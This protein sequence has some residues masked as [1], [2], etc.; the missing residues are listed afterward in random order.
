[1]KKFTLKRTILTL[2]LS[3]GLIVMPVSNN[4]ADAKTVSLDESL[5]AMWQHTQVQTGRVNGAYTGSL[6]SFSMRTPIRNWNIVSYTPPNFRAGCG[7]V[8][9]HFGSFSF[10]SGDNIKELMRQIMGSAL[11]YAV[12][13]AL[14]NVCA[15]CDE[16]LGDLQDLTAKINANSINTCKMSSTA[17]DWISGNKNSSDRKSEQEQ[18]SIDAASKGEKKDMSE[19]W[20]NIFSSSDGN[21]RKGNANR[22]A[23]AHNIDT[24]YGNNLLNT[25]VSTNLFE[26]IDTD[27]YGGDK[28]FFEIAMSLIGTNIM[29]TGSNKNNNSSQDRYIEPIWTLENLITGTP[30]NSQLDILSC[31]D[32]SQNITYSDAGKCQKVTTKQNDFKGT[33][34]V[35]IELLAGKQ[36]ALGDAQGDLL[37]SDIEPNSI[38]AWFKDNRGMTL[39]AE[40]Q[41]FVKQIPPTMYTTLEMV[42]KS[43]QD[44]ITKAVTVRASEILAE[45]MAANLATAIVSQTKMAYNA[46]ARK[47]AGS[48]EGKYIADMSANQKEAL[49][50]LERAANEVHRNADAKTDLFNQMVGRLILNSQQLEQMNKQ[51]ATLSI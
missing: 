20:S 17:I 47:N 37:I 39:S 2:V 5:G 9:F 26:H 18:E 7:G 50:K 34:R 6:G 31:N 49:N 43:N 3:F 46:H 51:S 28:Q 33:K 4:Q 22:D 45:Q 35:V 8:D 44:K 15:S 40:Q 1:M 12:R 16:I 42:A 13:L 32:L 10:I 19:A 25:Y 14:K 24:K 48:T 36:T 27:W 23:N 29:V 11:G 21:N 41:A 30:Q 38:M